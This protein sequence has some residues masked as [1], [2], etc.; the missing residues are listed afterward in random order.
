MSHR[1]ALVLPIG[2]SWLVLGC[3]AAAGPVS[4]SDEV[5]VVSASGGGTPGCDP[6]S[7]CS[8]GQYCAIALGACSASGACEDSPRVCPE[9]VKL[10]C[11]CDGAT[12]DNA[13]F[14][15]QAGVSVDHMG[16]CSTGG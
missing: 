8:T 9:L 3:G 6:S 5:A 12:Y 10:V 2:L 1:L 14:A 15:Q 16:A 4:E 13:C 7:G 11:G